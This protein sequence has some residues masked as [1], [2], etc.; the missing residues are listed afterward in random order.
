MWLSR[1]EK[2]WLIRVFVA[3]IPLTVLALS[4]HDTLE[5]D[6]GNATFHWAAFVLM[7]LVV[8]GVTGLPGAPAMQRITLRAVAPALRPF[9]VVLRRSP[10]V[11][12]PPPLP[13]PMD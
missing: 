2:L 12:L 13:P 6:W 7:A 11:P 4:I 3:V 1:P 10:S 9:G 8:Y 5:R